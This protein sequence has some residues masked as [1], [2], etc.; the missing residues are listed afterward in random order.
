[1]PATDSRSVSIPAVSSPGSRSH[2]PSVQY[3]S[4]RDASLRLASPVPSGAVSPR[5]TWSKRNQDNNNEDAPFTSQTPLPE[6]SLSKSAGPGA[7]ALANALHASGR[8]SPSQS[9]VAG[10]DPP[11]DKKPIRSQHDSFDAGTSPGPAGW[12]SPKEDFDV[13]RRHL[14][15]PQNVSPSNDD[16]N[17]PLSTRRGR[18][19]VSRGPGN[20]KESEAPSMGGDEFS[21]LRMQGG[22]ITRE[23]YRRTEAEERSRKGRQQRSQSFHVSRSETID[24][25][26]DYDNLR[27]PGGFR[28]NHIRRN[29]PSPA[30]KQVGYGSTQE[31]LSR[32]QPNMITRNFFEFLSLYGHFAGEEL[33]DDDEDGEDAMDDSEAALTLAQEQLDQDV[34]RRLPGEQRP[35]LQRN[36]PTRRRMKEDNTPKKGAGGTILILLKSFV[37]TG[38]LFLPRAFLNGGMLF[39]S[40]VLL[41]VSALSYFCFILLTK[42]RLALKASYA[43]MGGIVHG[44]WLRILINSSLVISQIGFASAYIVF[45]SENLQGFIL[46][47]SKGRTYID[48]KYVILMQLA[49][50]LPLSLYRNLNNISLV[51]Y[52]ADLFI[53]LGLIYLY[54]FDVATLVQQG[55]SDIQLFNKNSWTLFIGTAVFTFEGIGLLIPIQDGMKNPQQLPAVLGFVMVIITTIFVAMGALS[56]AAFGSKTETV[57]ILNMPQDNKFVN[58]VQFLYSLAILLSTPLQIFPVITIMEKGFFTKSGKYNKNTKWLKNGFR[59]IIVIASALIAWLGA[60]DLDKFVALVGSF[61]CIPLVYIYPVSVKHS[62][63]GGHHC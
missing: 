48:I 37:G 4:T 31:E 53:V 30:P 17:G 8:R 60:N 41:A 62:V 39:S 61:A 20:R 43:E 59:F 44:K 47:V 52:I 36:P 40:L 1:M 27:Q 26:L 24:D 33:D 22:D 28:R 25:D 18:G 7:S 21:S 46:A 11:D 29:A 23:I 13:I 34:R 54:Y 19:S 58:T 63:M 2:R 6:G 38:V 35:L 56:Y 51:V 16:L 14:A 9:N 50:F 12:Q 42:S 49:V 10:A 55:L 32:P 57:I 45:T 3:A 15:G 5:N